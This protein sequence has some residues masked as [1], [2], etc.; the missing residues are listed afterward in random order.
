MRRLLTF[1]FILSLFMVANGQELYVSDQLTAPIRTEARDNSRIKKMIQSGTKL[2]VLGRSGQHI[3][4]RYPGG[5]G[6]I[7]KSFVMDEPVA[8]EQVKEAQRRL[9]EVAELDNTVA[10]LRENVTELEAVIEQLTEEKEEIAQKYAQ[11]V[12]VSTQAVDIDRRNTELNEENYNLKVKHNALKEEHQL[13]KE[14]SR[15]T[16]WII[17]AVILFF[18]IIFGSAIMPWLVAKLRRKN[19]S[20][21]F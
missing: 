5:T 20:W 6:W 10:S 17:G 12:K 11:L 13:L 15:S 16:E 18:G 9:K 4:V 2:E 8:R 14:S 7:H 19:N 21:D 3:N 1:G